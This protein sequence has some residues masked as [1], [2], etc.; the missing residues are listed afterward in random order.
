MQEMDLITI[1]APPGAVIPKANFELKVAKIRGVES[2]R[3][4]LLRK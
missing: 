2:K 1:Y 4:A 3:Y